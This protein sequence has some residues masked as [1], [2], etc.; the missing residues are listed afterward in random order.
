MPDEPT[1]NSTAVTGPA[2][3]DAKAARSMGA[4]IA[5]A[6]TDDQAW[7]L[8]P[9]PVRAAMAA[10]ALS[11]SGR[12][13]NK[14]LLAELGRYSRTT[15]ERSN[16]WSAELAAVVR[17]APTVTAE[18]LSRAPEQ[19]DPTSLRRELDEAHRRLAQTRA[20]LTKMKAEREPLITYTAA[21]ARELRKFRQDERAEQESKVLYIVP[22]DPQPEETGNGVPADT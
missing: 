16:G 18:M 14:K 19:E 11:A 20:E 5:S 8:L 2:A 7:Q 17:L 15:A 10:V 9:I 13:V 21:L 4:L 1:R 12:R 3:L 6:M 22:S